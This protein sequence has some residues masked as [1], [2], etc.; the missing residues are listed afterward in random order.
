MKKVLLTATI[1]LSVLISACNTTD[2]KAPVSGGDS[3]SS[4]GAAVNP[5]DAPIIKFAKNSF[6]FGKVTD[7]EKVTHEFKFKN[8]GKSP[9]I[10]ANAEASCGCTVPEF[11][12]EPIPPGGE[13]VIKAVFNTLGKVGMQH[14]VVTVT[15]NAVPNSVELYIVGEVEGKP[16]DDQSKEAKSKR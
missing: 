6:D 15:S 14:K 7:G 12:H 1:A 3:V 9:L 16:F 8:E 11:P 13:G 10:I 2:R 5:E 4:S